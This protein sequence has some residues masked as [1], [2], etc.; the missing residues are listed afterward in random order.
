MAYNKKYAELGESVIDYVNDRE[1]AIEQ[2]FD[3][4]IGEGLFSTGSWVLKD[5][6]DNYYLVWSNVSTPETSSSYRSIQLPFDVNG[7]A[8]V[9]TVTANFN[10]TQ[11]VTLAHAILGSSELRIYPSILGEPLKSAQS[12]HIIGVLKKV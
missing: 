8:S 4:L 5:L 12:F 9:L 7:G 10:V 2:G 3:N 11:Y 6:G 1:D